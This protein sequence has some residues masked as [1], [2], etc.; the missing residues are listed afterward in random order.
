M[1][2]FWHHVNRQFVHTENPAFFAASGLLREVRRRGEPGRMGLPALRSFAAWGWGNDYGSAIAARSSA[3]GFF[4][5]SSG[6]EAGGFNVQHR[7]P[8]SAG[9]DACAMSDIQ[10]DRVQAFLLPRP[11]RRFF[12][13][14][15]LGLFLE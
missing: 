15:V 2:F 4:R 3:A 1:L 6:F 12:V 11:E 13:L 10:I 5:G 9:A 8:D 14:R 7:R